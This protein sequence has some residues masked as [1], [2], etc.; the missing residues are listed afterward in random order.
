MDGTVTLVEDKNHRLDAL[1]TDFL[2]VI[3]K[4]SLDI[5]YGGRVIVEQMRPTLG[6]EERISY[7]ISPVRDTQPVRTNGNK[8]KRSQQEDDTVSNE[9]QSGGRPA[10]TPFSNGVISGQL[11]LSPAENHVVVSAELNIKKFV[12]PQLSLSS[13]H[14]AVLIHQLKTSLRKL[15]VTAQAGNL[16]TWKLDR[17][18]RRFQSTK[19]TLSTVEAVRLFMKM[20]HIIAKI[21]HI[22]KEIVQEEAEYYRAI[23][24]WEHA[25]RAYFTWLSISPLPFDDLQSFL[26]V[27]QRLKDWPGCL[28]ALEQSAHE[29]EAALSAKLYYAASVLS[30][31]V[32]LDIDKALKFA[33]LAYRLT[34]EQEDIITLTSELKTQVAMNL[35]MSSDAVEVPS[36]TTHQLNKTKY[37]VPL[38]GDVDE[39][40]FFDDLELPLTEDE[41]SLQSEEA[42]LSEDS[43]GHKESAL[44]E[45]SQILEEPILHK[46]APQPE[47]PNSKPVNHPPTSRR[48]PRKY[49]G[50]NKQKRKKKKTKGKKR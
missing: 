45:D 2:R 31:D 11:H 22:S 30:R 48:K 47:E 8:E 5:T 27:L 28:Q 14:V 50:A 41:E 35:E 26:T 9:V 39:E 29:Y 7:L 1:E 19:P 42:I 4:N 25:R 36:K 24:R 43:Q 18:Q 23:E 46:D 34:P 40:H 44:S 17:V 32:F 49:R 38:E 33:E 21:T 12:T 37:Q 3:S 15:K 20:I 16:L 13:A 6:E 10:S